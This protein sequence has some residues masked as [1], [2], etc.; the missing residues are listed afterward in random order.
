MAIRRVNITRDENI[1]D[2]ERLSRHPNI[3]SYLRFPWGYTLFEF[4]D[5]IFDTLDTSNPKAKDA[6]RSSEETQARLAAL[7]SEERKLLWPLY[8]GRPEHWQGNQLGLPLET[9]IYR[10]LDRKKIEWPWF[11]SSPGWES[12][13]KIVICG[14]APASAPDSRVSLEGVFGEWVE[15]GTSGRELAAADPLVFHGDMFRTRCHFNLSC[16]D[17]CIGLYL[18][19]S[20]TRE[21]TLLDAVG[22]FRPSESSF[23]FYEIGGTGVLTLESPFA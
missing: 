9:G 6:Q 3:R 21:R 14:R 23:K 10:V 2:Q 11:G 13:N 8:K 7:M 20:K 1:E 16:C 12:E 22:F 4:Y 15:W 5:P 17:A 19:L 18:L